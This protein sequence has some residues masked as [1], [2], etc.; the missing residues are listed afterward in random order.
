[1]DKPAPDFAISIFAVPKP[2]EGHIATIQRNA[3]RSWKR[4]PFVERIVLIGGEEG[5][6]AAAE[7]FGAVHLAEVHRDSYGTPLLDDVFRL[8][9]AAAP[10]EWLLYVNADILLTRRFAESVAIA[11]AVNGPGLIVSR[12]WNADVTADLELDWDGDALPAHLA[13]KL[14]ELF[15]EWGIDVF[16][17]PKSLFGQIP[18]FSLGRSWWDNWLVN[19]A[20]KSGRPVTDITE[21]ATVI[22]QNHAYEKFLSIKELR[23]SQQGLR[24]F[25][26]AGDSYFGIAN[27]YDATH[28][29]RD[30]AIVPRGTLSVSIVVAHAGSA[31]ELRGSIAAL[32]YQSYPRTYLE[33]IVVETANGTGGA[34][35]QLECPFV[36][37]AR[38]SRSGPPAAR[39]KGA[40]IAGGEVLA[41]LDSNCRPAGDWIERAVAAVRGPCIVACH[42]RN[43]GPDPC[44]ERPGPGI[45]AAMLVPAAAWRQIGPFDEGSGDAG[46]EEWEWSR[47]ASEAGVVFVSA[48]D[49]VV[50]GPIARGDAS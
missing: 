27:I 18:P 36:K 43:G 12:R 15:S 44:T 14:P 32:A 3:L 45:A 42:V 38:E 25:W 49:A 20:R 6:A 7:S 8:G 11:A 47:R 21:Q 9:A 46:G 10:T 35:I 28:V 33:V 19:T 23:V 16:A 1:M 39:N 4:L 22:H 40:A 24:N 13:G 17:F 26:L 29:L 31:D 5:T 50:T 34:L 2:F 48:A 37:L 30:G 41:F